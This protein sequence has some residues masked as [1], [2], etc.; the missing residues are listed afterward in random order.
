MEG[1]SDTIAGI[2]I[3]HPE[4][5]IYADLGVT[6]L[7]VAR[8]YHDVSSWM[9]PHVLG[10]PLTLLRCGA[11]ID[12]SADK[13]GCVMMRHGKAWGPSALRR[14]QIRELRKTGEYLVA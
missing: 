13:G 4:R 1:A 12:P 8:Y 2:R 7:D 6:K 11:T 14:V 10:R 9:L 3:S 5:L